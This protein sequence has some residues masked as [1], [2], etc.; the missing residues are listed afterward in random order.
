MFVCASNG[1]ED[2]DS[3]FGKGS[4][5]G[6]GDGDG[7]WSGVTRVVGMPSVDIGSLTSGCGSVGSSDSTESKR[8][9]MVWL[10]SSETPSSSC[11]R[12][13]T[14]SL[15]SVKVGVKDEVCATTS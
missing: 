3:G 15:A 12:S 2:G 10:I 13:Q 4:E 9:S 11:S 1:G 14:S 6:G 8:L 5:V 7:E